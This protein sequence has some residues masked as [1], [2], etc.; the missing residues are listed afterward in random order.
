[1]RPAPI[2]TSLPTP[3]KGTST[4]NIF[5]VSCHN[6]QRHFTKQ[7]LKNPEFNFSKIVIQNR[8]F[9]NCNYELTTGKMK[10]ESELETNLENQI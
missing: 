10:F 6:N 8:T 3:S 9:L 7:K 1:M 5:S 2:S 4:P